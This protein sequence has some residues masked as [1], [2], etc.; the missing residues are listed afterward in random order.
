MRLASVLAPRVVL[1]A[2]ERLALADRVGEVPVHRGDVV[3]VGRVFGLQLPVGAH[4]VGALALQHLHA[5]VRLV[6]HQVDERPGVPEKRFQILYIR[7][8]RGENEAA[9]GR[10]PRDR[11]EIGAEPLQRLPAV[12]GIAAPHPDAFPVGVE[13]PAVIAAGDGRL[14]ARAPARQHRA[15]VR[16]GIVEAADFAVEPAN[17]EHRI[18]SDAAPDVLAALADLAVVA[19]IVPAALENPLHLALEQVPARRRPTA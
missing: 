3:A 9:I 5:L 18:A 2:G 13:G 16:A 14:N 6:G 4:D 7:I 17:R 8:Q 12:A 1:L 15:A 11:P 10:D 19:D